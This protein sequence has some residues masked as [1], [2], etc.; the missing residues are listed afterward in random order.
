MWALRSR[1]EKNR[2]NQAVCLHH[3]QGNNKYWLIPY[4]HT[5]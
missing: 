4:V 2:D 3:I 1:K 5:N